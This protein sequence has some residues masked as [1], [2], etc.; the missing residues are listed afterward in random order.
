MHNFGI[1]NL[2][3]KVSIP[4]GSIKITEIYRIKAELDGFNSN[5]F[6]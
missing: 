2:V 4:T 6:D 3:Y 5:W 1:V